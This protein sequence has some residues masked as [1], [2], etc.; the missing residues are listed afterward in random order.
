MISCYSS[1]LILVIFNN[2]VEA[3]PFS[4]C[5]DDTKQFKVHSVEG[6]KDCSWARKAKW[7]CHLPAIKL[8]CMQTCAICDIADHFAPKESPI[9]PVTTNLAPTVRRSSEKSGYGNEINSNYPWC[10]DVKGTFEVFAPLGEVFV[11]KCK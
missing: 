3:F 4:G 2:L 10:K 1:L 6:E 11:R 5:L 8:H 7:K 9:I